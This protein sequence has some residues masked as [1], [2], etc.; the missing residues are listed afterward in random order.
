MSR[1]KKIA[2]LG[3]FTAVAVVLSY[4]EFLIPLTFIP[5][6][7]FK[8]GLANISIMVALYLFGPVEA[9]CIS[10]LRL[11]L[12]LF[13]FS[14][15]KAFLYSL[16]GAILSLAVMILLKRI[17]RF[18]EVGVSVTG[19]VFHNIGQLAAASLL[20]A[21]MEIWSYLPVLVIAAVITGSLTGLIL[22]FILPVIRPL[23]K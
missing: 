19:A 17:N 20:M 7:G 12:S 10:A 9:I 16:I 2:V 22:H 5:V 15:L 3:I 6:P 1:T 11:V 18:N 14:N 21:S 8:L 4:V 23:V 13:L